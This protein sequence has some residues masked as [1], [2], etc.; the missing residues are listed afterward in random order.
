MVNFRSK[1]SSGLIQFCLLAGIFSC[2]GN[3][4]FLSNYTSAS[5]EDGVALT[6]RD[7][8]TFT[9][10]Y[11]ALTS[12]DS[13]TG[14]FTIIKDTI[15]FHHSDQTDSASP[16]KRRIGGFGPLAISLSRRPAMIRPSAMLRIGKSLMYIDPVS[17]QIL[18]SSSRP[19]TG[20]LY[21][22]GHK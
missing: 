18:M 9:F 21:L 11:E 1:P 17:K 15:F 13:S 14:T 8:S 2:S 16:G 6:L 10:K 12:S 19:E 20:F 22:I 3:Q 4:P 5:T 7:D